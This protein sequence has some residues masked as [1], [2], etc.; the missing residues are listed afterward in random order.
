MMSVTNSYDK[1][2]LLMPRLGYKDE[3]II[4]K[5]Y[6]Q[7]DD[8]KFGKATLPDINYYG[9]RESAIEDYVKD[10]FKSAKETNKRV[11]LTHLTSTAHHPF[12]MPDDEVYVPLASGDALED[13]SHYVNAIGFVDRWLDR[14]LE[15]LEEQGVSEETLVV[16]VGDH[17]L[18]LPETASITPYYQPHIGNFH[19]PLVLSHPKLPVVDIQ[20]AVSSI[21]ILPTILDLLI[22]TGSLSKSEREAAR[23]LVRNYEGQSLI[24]PLHK[25]SKHT[26][27]ADWQFTV[28]NT[29]R[30]QVATRSARDPA[31]R[32]I[33]PVI[34]DIEWRFTNVEEDPHEEDAILSFDFEAFLHAIEEK[35]GSDAAKWTEEASFITRWWVDENAKRWRFEP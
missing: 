24:R 23:D 32:L 7:R 3:E 30:A 35:Y 19:V 28:M 20:S 22:E 21:S 12:K 11:F 6:L 27:Q 33:V 17:G 16:L 34:K 26:G 31:W 8:A 4:S 10:A 2:D 9:M 25:A 5:E 1:Q 18:S 29:G 15:I 13:L 14:I